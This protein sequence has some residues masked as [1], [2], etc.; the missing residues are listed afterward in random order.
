MRGSSFNGYAGQRGTRRKVQGN[1]ERI[2]FLFLPCALYPV[3]SAVLLG[4]AQS[5]VRWAWILYFTGLH[6][7]EGY[8][9]G[10]P[11]EGQGY[12]G[13]MLYC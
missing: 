11:R 7:V 1:K 2:S 13:G 4:A 9:S 6:L 3:P 5:Q 8:K 12:A 10:V